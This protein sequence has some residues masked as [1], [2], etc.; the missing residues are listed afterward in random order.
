MGAYLSGMRPPRALTSLA[1]ALLA[2]AA[3]TAPLV[4]QGAAPYPL[5]ITRAGVEIGR[6]EIIIRPEQR[7]L[8]GSTISSVASYPAV[9][10][11]VRISLT[12]ERAPDGSLTAAQLDEQTPDHAWRTYAAVSPGRLTVRSATEGRESAR[13]YPAGPRTV[14]LDDSLYA[15][16]IAVA[17]FATDSG[18][19]LEAVWL[20][21]GRRATITARRRATPDGGA[22][23]EVSGALTAT[24]TLTRDGHLL[25]IILPDRGIAVAPPPQ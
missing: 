22:S 3:P 21:S 1:G 9:R 5:V 10:S 25:R 7:G 6:E 23:V 15:P 13:E 2:L 11:R 12:L 8:P 4:A 18:A 16:W 19:S 20:R 24:L 17:S 14:V